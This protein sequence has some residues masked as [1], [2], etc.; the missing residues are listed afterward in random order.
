MLNF[1]LN[2]YKS[3]LAQ[4][5][6]II[7]PEKLLV[8]QLGAKNAEW[9]CKQDIL[10]QLQKEEIN[11]LTLE[12]PYGENGEREDVVVFW[13]SGKYVFEPVADHLPISYSNIL[14]EKVFKIGVND[15]VRVIALV[16]G[17]SHVKIAVPIQDG[18]HF[19]GIRKFGK[20]D[21][22]LLLF[23]GNPTLDF[24]RITEQVKVAQGFLPSS[25]FVVLTFV[26]EVLLSVPDELNFSLSEMR[27]NLL[28]S[29]QAYKEHGIILQDIVGIIRY[30]VLIDY[31]REFIFIFGKQL[32][33][34]KGTTLFRYLRDFIIHTQHS[35][36]A[37]ADFCSSF[38]KDKNGEASRIIGER[39][40]EITEALEKALGENSS[41]FEFAVSGLFS[42]RSGFLKSR[43]K[44]DDV[45]DWGESF[46][47]KVSPNDDS[48]Y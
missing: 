6:D 14:P 25:S 40:K 48:S 39:K 44:Q 43:F 15:F 19:V 47:P 12:L 41:E 2:N 1:D 36:I 45:F 38:C 18:F 22:V 13:Q 3:Y 4:D 26:K 16:N 42:Y 34:Q 29:P 27:S 30:P 11:N 23:T 9:I 31:E 20:R 17:F 28:V 21:I 8:D 33:K 46:S 35:E 7:L 5:G 10:K 32:T 24:K 37:Y